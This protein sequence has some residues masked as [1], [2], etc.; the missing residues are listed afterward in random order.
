M[1]GMC[2]QQQLII[3]WRWHGW[4]CRYTGIS[5]RY[6]YTGAGWDSL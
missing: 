3:L 2:G 6:Y 1:G 5:K 4:R